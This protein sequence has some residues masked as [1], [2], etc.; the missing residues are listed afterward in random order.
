MD[1]ER[2]NRHEE[3][4]QRAELRQKHDAAAALLRQ[5]HEDAEYRDGEGLSP[6]EDREA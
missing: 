5:K 1:D 2:F 3:R 4:R 6:P